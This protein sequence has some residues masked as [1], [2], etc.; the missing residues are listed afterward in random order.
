[1]GY[2][3]IILFVFLGGFIAWA[4]LSGRFT[5]KGGGASVTKEPKTLHTE[6]GNQPGVDG[7]RGDSAAITNTTTDTST[8][9]NPPS[10]NAQNMP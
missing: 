6:P 4:L 5:K 9:V 7:P 2:E 8:N 10:S 1:M 3:L